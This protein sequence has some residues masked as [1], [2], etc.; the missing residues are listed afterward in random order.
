MVFCCFFKKPG[1][2]VIPWAYMDIIYTVATTATCCSAYF[3]SGGKW[4]C[5]LWMRFQV[6]YCWCIAHQTDVSPEL[7]TSGASLNTKW[8][9]RYKLC[10]VLIYSS[11]LYLMPRQQHENQWHL[12]LI[13]G[14]KYTVSIQQYTIYGNCMLYWFVSCKDIIDK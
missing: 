7:V 10:P 9:G 3:S 1:I 8:G 4:G 13:Y 6:E 12:L 5:C 11:R 2:S 14:I